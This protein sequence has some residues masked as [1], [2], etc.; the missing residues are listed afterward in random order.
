MNNDRIADAAREFVGR[1]RATDAARD[2]TT[3]NFVQSGIL[4]RDEREA[5]AQ[6]LAAVD[7]PDPLDI[8]KPEQA[9]R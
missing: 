1:I 7:E 6:L 4:H 9:S 5:W 2:R 8:E 3:L